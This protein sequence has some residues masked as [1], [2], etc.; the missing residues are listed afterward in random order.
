MLP[1]PWAPGS[2]Q[3][4]QQP[5]QTYEPAR[6]QQPAAATTHKPASQ[7]A[8]A[9]Q[10]QQGRSLKIR[11]PTA[12][13]AGRVQIDFQILQI[14]KVPGKDSAW[15][16]INKNSASIIHL[17]F[18]IISIGPYP[19]LPWKRSLVTG[20]SPT[21]LS[22]FSFFGAA[23]TIANYTEDTGKP[24]ICSGSLLALEACKL[25]S[26]HRT[27]SAHTESYNEIAQRQNT[28]L[29]IL[30]CSMNHVWQTCCIYVPV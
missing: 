18:Y 26:V 19:A 5:Q 29:C 17:I 21:S 8:P 9:S 20:R 30:V 6:S 14:L 2:Q 25:A 4:A 7:P 3:P 1:Q 16:Y 27:V 13:G 28:C 10:S 12:G 15:A 11:R 24:K 22:L 23:L